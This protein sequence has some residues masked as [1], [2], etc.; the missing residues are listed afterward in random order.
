MPATS[1]S[2]PVP[3]CLACG[4]KRENF[5]SERV[6]L[7]YVIRSYRCP[8]CRTVFRIAEPFSSPRKKRKVRRV[9]A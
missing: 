1:Q 3:V 2:L 9:I 8:R 4:V 5:R 7:H 6:T